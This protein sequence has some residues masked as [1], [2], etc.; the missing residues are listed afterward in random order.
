MSLN[1]DSGVAAPPLIARI[2]NDLIILDPRTLQIDEP[3]LIRD[4]LDF[5]LRNLKP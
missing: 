2:E 5:I 1:N 4:A 3:D